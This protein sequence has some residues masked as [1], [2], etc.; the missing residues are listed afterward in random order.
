MH[1]V[2]D[3]DKIWAYVFA[4]CMGFIAP[5]GVLFLWLL[6]FIL[7]DLVTGV[8]A[9][10]N[11][12]QI[13][14]SH[15]LQKTV[16]KFITYATAVFLLHGIDV[17]MVVF[18]ELYLARIGAT[19]ICGIELYSIFENMYRVTGN[20]VFKILTQ[21]TKKKIKQETGVDVNVPVHKKPIH[22]KGRADEGKHK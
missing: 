15:G 8:C 19:I 14:T 5:I 9:A 6:I 11:E 2:L 17:Y 3:L 20:E 13:I 16:I 21:F 22:K 10:W 7:V 18:A 12:G 4:S 1:K